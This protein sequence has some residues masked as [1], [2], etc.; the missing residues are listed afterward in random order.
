[1]AITT[2]LFDLDGTLLPMDQEVFIKAYFG[3]LAKTLAPHG[4]DPQQL[5]QAVWTGTK[6]MQVNDGSKTNEQAFWDSFC[7]IM[8]QER[9]QDEALF[10]SFYENQFNQVRSACGF[11]PRAAQV[12]ARLKEKGLKVALAT[13]PLF[14]AIATEN[15]IAWAGLKPED[16]LLYTVYENSSRCK[17]NP[18]YYRDV[19]NA[20][21]VSPEEC[22]MV[23]NDVAEDMAARKLGM[24][25]FLLTDCVINKNNED[26][27]AYPHGGFD[28]LLAF[29]EKL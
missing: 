15:R 5:I 18:D 9:R 28:E 22:L 1:M 12:V 21:G 10:R 27:S 8:G 17:P 13:N 23:G 6:A 26:I 4:Y 3:L 11:D 24:E 29:I 7:T 16:F 14:P 20:L 25:V 19:V 2:V